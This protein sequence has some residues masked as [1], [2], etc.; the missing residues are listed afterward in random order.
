MATNGLFNGRG[1]D[2]ELDLR[3]DLIIESIQNRGVDVLYV[4]RQWVSENTLL[5]E[6]TISSFPRAYEIEARVEGI[7][8]MVKSAYLLSTVNFPM[9]LSNL[10]V[11]VSKTRFRQEVPDEAL[12]F[13]GRPNEGDLIY[14]P[15]ISTLLE[16]TSADPDNLMMSGGRLMVYELKCEF[17]RSNAENVNGDPATGGLGDIDQLPQILLDGQLVREDDTIV[18]VKDSGPRKPLPGGAIKQERK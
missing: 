7:E 11:T 14:V 9:Q 8:Q 3:D 4:P 2:V 17:F 5:G 1:E 12:K 13:P 16:I 10:T 6:V 18:D 15:H